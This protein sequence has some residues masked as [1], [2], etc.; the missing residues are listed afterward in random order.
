M[1]RARNI[2]PA[3]FK[4]EFLAEMAVEARML[5]IG[6]W[7]LSDR[8]GRL[9]D[10]PK[11]ISLEL[12]PFDKFDVDSMLNDLQSNKFLVRYEV[13]GIK[14]IQIINF[15]KHQD[16]HYREKASEIPAPMGFANEIAATN[17]TRAQR[18]RIFER[19]GYVCQRCPSKEHLCIDHIIPVSRGGNSLD[20]NLQ[21]L[22]LSCN[23]KK[24]NKVDSTSNQPRLNV[25]SNGARDVR[26]NPDSL[27]PD[28]LNPESIVLADK[29]PAVK[30]RTQIPDD[31]EPD[32]TG[33]AKANES[34]I[35]IADEI[36]RFK[37]F[38]RG[39]GNTMLDWQAAWR[40]W[41]SN[42]VKFSKGKSNGYV[43]AKD[44]ER[45]RV[46][47]GLTGYDSDAITGVSQRVD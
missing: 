44:A 40:T 17:V 41:V 45:K 22:C 2:K 6:L 27:N 47:R 10:R 7:T 3:F 8:E 38:H 23:T 26:L 24:G 19:D 11:R 21:V 12:F 18:A 20:D 30:R 43:S 14:Y 4:N 42:A 13:D 37:D 28:S 16:P 35:P 15:V 9:E 1:A 34:G 39:K 33:T 32:E 46:I 29:P 36:E 5:F 31:F 25:E